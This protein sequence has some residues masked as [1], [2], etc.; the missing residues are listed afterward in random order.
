MNRLKGSRVYLSGAMEYCP[1]FGA[2]WRKKVRSDLSDLGLVFLDP[3]DKPIDVLDE[4]TLIQNIKVGRATEDYDSIARDVKLIR[5]IDL[6]MCDMADVLIVNIDLTIPTCGTWEELFTANR[7]KKP[8]L[9][10]IVQG[11]ASGPAWLFGT[12]P[13]QHIFSAWKEIYDYLNLV[14]SSDGTPDFNRWLFFTLDSVAT[15]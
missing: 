11:K 10:R 2:D 8:I 6:R 5:H 12:I 3:T 1:D 9:V 14:D 7:A 13:H 4:K 15:K